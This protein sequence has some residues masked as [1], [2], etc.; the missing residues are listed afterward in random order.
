MGLEGRIRKLEE[1]AITA[2]AKRPRGPVHAR[3][4][5]DDQ[6][7]AV[8]TRGRLARAEDLTD[9]ALQAMLNLL[10]GGH[11]PTD[12]ELDATLA[13]DLQAG[14]KA[15][16]PAAQEVAGNGPIVQTEG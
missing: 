3:D 13:G 16:T 11:E 1:A 2:A 14:L 15:E 9:V 5:T 7:V 8:L 4:M 6:L 10:H 12:E